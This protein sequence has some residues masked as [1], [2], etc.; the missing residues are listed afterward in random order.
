MNHPH[1]AVAVTQLPQPYRV[2]LNDNLGHQWLSDEPEDAGGQN[3]ATTPDRMLLGALGAC[4]AI[5]LRMYAQRKGWPLTG[6][7]VDL[8]LN[9]Q[10]KPE[11]GA[12]NDIARVIRLE[13]DLD[14][15]QRARLMQ[16]AAACPVHKLLTGQ[17]RVSTTEAAA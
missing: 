5:T 4:T 6:V 17:V 11:A 8:Q 7:T 10:G 1:A 3:T 14:A 12:G 2:Q 16:I 15:G 13:G 9:P